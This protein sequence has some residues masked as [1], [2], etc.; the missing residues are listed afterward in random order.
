[1]GVNFYLVCNNN[2]IS[3]MYKEPQLWIK[4]REKMNRLIK[5]KIKNSQIHNNMSIG[6]VIV[7]VIVIVMMVFVL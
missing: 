1:M 3:A 6:F 2:L 4:W 5:N 7:I